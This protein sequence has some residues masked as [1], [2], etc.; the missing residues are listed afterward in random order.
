MLFV[1][2]SRCSKIDQFDHVIINSL[3]VDV[4]WLDVSMYNILRVKVGER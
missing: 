4:L 3:K 2:S 1:D